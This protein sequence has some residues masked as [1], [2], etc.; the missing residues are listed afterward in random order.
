MEKVRKKSL[1]NISIPYIDG[2]YFGKATFDAFTH[3]RGLINVPKEYVVSHAAEVIDIHLS[4]N[5]A[6][7][8]VPV[9]SLQRRI[10]QYCS[11]KGD[12]FEDPGC[13]NV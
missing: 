13:L 11:G 8:C 9:S 10:L 4:Q 2:S 3:R 5:G 12:R 7:F 1:I 6:P